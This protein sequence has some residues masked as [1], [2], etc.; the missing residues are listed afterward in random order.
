MRGRAKLD[1]SRVIQVIGGDSRGQGKGGRAYL[2]S[3]RSESRS[4]REQSGDFS[5]QRSE[6]PT[7]HHAT[8]R[9]VT[10]RASSARF[11][12]WIRGARAGV[13][14]RGSAVDA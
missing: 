3:H 14:A 5:P 11:R 8:R 6:A 13:G 12:E 4:R 2:P 9:K 10:I 1:Y 7:K